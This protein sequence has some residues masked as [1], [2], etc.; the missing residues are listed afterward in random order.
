MRLTLRSLLAYLDEVLEPADMEE[1]RKKLDENEFTR[2]LEQ[3]VRHTADNPD[4]TAPAPTGPQMVIDP[5]RVAEYLDNVMPAEQVEEFEKQVLAS[6]EM[7]AELAN[8]HH[9]L[10][11]ILD[12]PV[13]VPAPRREKM[14]HLMDKAKELDEQAAKEPQPSASDQLEREAV[15]AVSGVRPEEVQTELPAQAADT[16]PKE[17]QPREKQEIP[18]YLREEEP[19]WRGLV[20]VVIVAVILVAVLFI[21]QVM[22]PGDAVVQD[23][24]TTTTESGE[25]GGTEENGEKTTEPAEKTGEDSGKTEP[26]KG[27]DTEPKKEPEK[28]PAET[29]PKKEPSETEPKKEP[30]KEP[31]TEP[32]KEPKK[33]PAETEPKKEPKKEPVTEPVKETPKEPI[34]QRM[35]L[36]SFTSPQTI[37]LNYQ[38]P[39]AE[40]PADWK[41]LPPRAVVFSGDRLVTAP[42]F[43]ANLTLS[44]GLNVT[45]LGG[46]IVN[47]L[48][49]NEQGIPGINLVTGRMIVEAMQADASIRVAAADHEWTLTFPQ[50][51]SKAAVQIQAEHKPG[52]DPLQQERSVTGNYH[53]TLGQVTISDGK[54]SVTASE[55]PASGTLVPLQATA[56]SVPEWI[57]AS[58]V[59]AIDARAGNLLEKEVRSDESALIRLKELAVDRRLEIRMLALRSLML[60]REFQPVVEALADEMLR[61]TSRDE[62]IQHLKLAVASDPKT[63]GMVQDAFVAKFGD[64]DGAAI[65]RMLWGYSNEQLAGAPNDAARLVGYL[66]HPEYVYRAVAF[67]TLQDITGLTLLYRPEQTADKREAALNRW[68]AK[69]EEGAIK[70]KD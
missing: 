12:Q 7:I 21:W 41:R 59:S 37:L 45:L 38:R 63:A 39:M 61:P 17:K 35:E 48:P 54:D 50:A 65:F 47:L 70:H 10:K 19:A 55:V 3:T 56:P 1:I 69:L 58:D 42:T 5:N 46:A 8:A 62:L 64:D 2:N 67:K 34:V 16:T 32:K 14:Y 28:E 66:D 24:K 9:I 15:A 29:E 23:D 27:T 52:T 43:R 57:E 26:G 30:V 6:E 49:A 51:D 68:R 4:I 25:K 33:E 60:V 44:G 40:Q 53:V 11:L 22:K 20:P 18:E 13:R 36:G 31:V